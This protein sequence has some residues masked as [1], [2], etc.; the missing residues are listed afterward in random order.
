MRLPLR[1]APAVFLAL[2]LT[3]TGCKESVLE[4][5]RF[6]SIQGRV[7]DFETGDPIAGASITTSP[8][9]GAIVTNNNGEFSIEEVLAGNYTITG[10]KSGYD[11]NTVTVAVLSERTTQ[12]TL[13]LSEEDTTDTADDASMSV[14]VLNFTNQVGT[15]STDVRVQYRVRN[16]GEVTI[17]SY[18][19]Y[20]TILTTG[21]TYFEEQQ[22]TNLGVGQQDIGEFTEF[23][24]QDSATAV[25]ID[26]F[27]FE[28]QQRLAGAA[29]LGNWPARAGKGAPTPIRRAR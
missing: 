24:G 23:I 13:F 14:E 4:P 9:T 7:L 27:F 17:P 8:P 18:E 12:A 15:D 10:N 6:G 25:V 1:T 2:F 11:P 26:T 22:G 20:F 5:E 19:V 3:A 28:G 16:T 21:D 29:F